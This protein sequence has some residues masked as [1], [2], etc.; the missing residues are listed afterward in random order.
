MKSACEVEHVYCINT[1]Y[2][3]G[4]FV[5]VVIMKILNECYVIVVANC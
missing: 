2:F 4:E 1:D 5:A 3:F